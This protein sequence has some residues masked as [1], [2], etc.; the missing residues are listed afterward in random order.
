M[1]RLLKLIA[2][3]LVGIVI[4]AF[5]FMIIATPFGWHFDVVPTGSMEPLIMPGG[6]VISRPVNP[7]NISVG[8]IVL[9][10]E[11]MTGDFICHRVININQTSKGTFFQT[12]GD[13][14]KNPDPN[15]V[16]AQ[17]IAGELV[18]YIPD[19]GN[20]AYSSSLYR[21]PLVLFG[22]PLSLA[23]ILIIGIC[24]ILLIVELR[25]LY[26]WILTPESRIYKE[27][28]KENKKRVLKRKKAFRIG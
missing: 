27:R 28:Y 18:L 21:S 14:N 13:A 10:R 5:L 26:D 6:L 12:K 11:Q 15:L 20:I 4:S 22:K 24:F 16:P 23:S 9:Y 7:E 25:N 17:N 19:I 2:V 8:E 3:L 1:I